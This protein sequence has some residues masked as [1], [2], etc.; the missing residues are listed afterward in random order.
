M[1]LTF[2]HGFLPDTITSVVPGSWSIA[3]EM[4]FYVIFPLLFGLLL[5][6]R[7]PTALAIAIVVTWV[8]YITQRN[9][10]AYTAHNIPDPQQAAL[11]NMFFGLTLVN[12]LPCFLIG[13]LVFKWLSEERPVPYPYLLVVG[14][15]IAA[16]WIALHQHGIPL[17]G[18]LSLPMQYGVVFAVFA[19]GLSSWQPSFLVNPVVGWVGKIS[20]SAYLVHFALLSIIP[21][22]HDNF[23]EAFL[24]LAL[25]TIAISSVTFR[26]IEQPFIRLG[27]RIAARMGSSSFEKEKLRSNSTQVEAGI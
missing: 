18:R 26:W 5:R 4:A 2:T 24:T 11:W 13:M 10:Y 7:F 6:I 17:F 27:H 3:D 14:A 12:Q 16:V 8:C 25:I 1:A 19:L 21:I 20:Y 15:V 23:A 22:P 9:L